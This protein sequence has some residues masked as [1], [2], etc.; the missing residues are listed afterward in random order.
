MYHLC[1]YVPE[2]HV[3]QVKT[4]IFEAGGGRIG[5]YDCCAWQV[6]GLGQFRPGTNST[7]FIGSLGNIEKVDEFRVELVVDRPYIEAV[8]AAL[9]ASHPYEEPAYHVL[10]VE[11]F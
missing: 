10:K 3:E 1:F 7:P 4:A 5:D 2:S 6:K 9:K 8:I 11:D